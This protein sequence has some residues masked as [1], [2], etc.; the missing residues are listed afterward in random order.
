MLHQISFFLFV[1]S[2]FYANFAAMNQVS[3]FIFPLVGEV[4]ESYTEISELSS[5]G[6]NILFR[7]K[8]NG[9]WWILK[10]LAPDVRF[11]STYLQLQQKEYDI[12]ARLAHPGIVKVE[13]LEE[14]E[15]YGRCIV[16]EWVDGVTLDEWLTQKHSCAER[17]QIVRQLLLVMEYVHDQQ[18]V[19]RDLKPANIMVARNGGTIKLIDFGLS[20]ADSYAILKSPA[21]TDGYVSP[22]QQKDSMPDVRNDIYSLGAILKEMHLGLSYRWVIK[23]CLCPMEQRYPNVHSLRMHIW[24]FQHRLVTMVWITFFLVLVASGVAI[25]NKVTKPA[26]LY[27]VV[28]HF[29]VGNLEYKSWGGGLVT[30]CAANEKDSVIEIPLSVNYQGMSYRVDEIEDSAFAALPQLRRIMFPDNP[31][32]HVMKHIFDDSP[33]LESISFRCKTPPVLG[34]DIWKVKMPDVFNL[35]CFEHVVLY[36]PK[37]SAAAY[38]RS[39]WGCFRN[40]E[41]YK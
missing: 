25:Y 9:Q 28:A 23:R 34:N 18:I 2:L 12:L 16:M 40:I 36:V 8:R 6:F 27:D 20:D 19:H 4:T 10:A 11:D 37:G 39:V 24:S 22:E 30:V 38:R 32:L 5:S 35:A 15:G 3:G 1:K 41:E 14:V 21:G 26:E 7:A 13:G 31:D 17:S 33:Q 29:T